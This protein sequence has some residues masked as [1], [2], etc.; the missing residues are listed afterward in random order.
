MIQ[1]II[2]GSP[3]TGKSHLIK[4]E[5][6]PKELQ[7]DEKANPENVIK[8]VFHPEYTYGDFMGKLLP[9]STKSNVEYRFYE[10]HFLKALAQAYANILKTYEYNKKERKIRKKIDEN[11]K[12]L[13]PNNVTLIID[14]I[15]RGNSSAIFGS[16]FQL[17]DRKDNGWSSYDTTIQGVMFAKLFSMIGF[18]TT[19][20]NDKT[21]ETTHAT[22]SLLNINSQSLEDINEELEEIF[23]K[24]ECREGFDVV[25]KTIKIPP[26]LHIIA[27]MNTSDSSIYHMDTA[28]KR[29]WEWQFIDVNS[30]PIREQGNAF[31][32]NSNNKDDP[33]NKE[34]YHFI[35][36]LNQFIKSNHNYIRG[37]EDKQIG[38][39]FIKANS[40][41][42]IEYS[43]I[44]S[45]LMFFIWDSVFNR[46]KIPLVKLLFGNDNVEQNKN[47]LVTFG[48]F[49]IKVKEFVK[50]IQER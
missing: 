17:L 8:A 43:I 25:N 42:Q 34:Y 22:L 19:S 1:R 14:E 47:K 16:V 37:I 9:I 30:N 23:G 32:Y 49:A 38:R 4:S 41:N 24:G 20:T 2:F 44:Q 31:Y 7:I 6:I 40:Q 21:G 28:F 45:K 11:G 12:E 35:D 5:I 36:K 50:A 39:Y 3:G 18:E 26:N 13:Q 46:D 29:R 33:N 15:N 10:G 48:D 27:T